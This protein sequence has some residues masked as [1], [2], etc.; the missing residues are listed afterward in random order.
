MNALQIVAMR[1]YKLRAVPVFSKQAPKW[2]G[3]LLR[4]SELFHFHKMN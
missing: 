3:R 4:P 1:H 2:V